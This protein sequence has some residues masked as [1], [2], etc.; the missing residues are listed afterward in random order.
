MTV[1]Y[2]EFAELL[3][4]VF[5]ILQPLYF[6]QTKETDT[7]IKSLFLLEYNRKNNCT[8]LKSFV[9]LKCQYYMVCGLP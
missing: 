1:L 3:L 4:T 8:K 6:L 7:T 9:W 5:G 2:A